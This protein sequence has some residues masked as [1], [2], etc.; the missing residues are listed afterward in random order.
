MRI[1]T[2]QEIFGPYGTG[3]LPAV[4]GPRVVFDIEGDGLYETI[5]QV[6][7][8]CTRD[9]DTGEERSFPP[10]DIA[11]GL[12]YLSSCSTLVGHNIIDFDLPV[13]RDLCDWRPA[14]GTS[15]VDTLV[16]SRLSN[17]DRRV[18]AG[19]TG[20]SGP[21]SL[22]VWGYRV[23]K[24]KPEHEDWSQYSP[25]M[26]ARCQ[27]DVLINT[28]VY[29][30][31]MEEL[32]DHKWGDSVWIEHVVARIMSEQARTG[33]CFDVTAAEKLIEKLIGEIA[34]VDAQLDPVLPVRWLQFKTPITKPF[35][36]DG[37]YTQQVINWLYDSDYLVDE[38]QVCGPFSRVVPE[39]MNTNSDK[40]LKEFLLSQGWEPIAYNYDKDG[41]PTSPKLEFSD[42]DDDGISDELGKLIKYRKMCSHRKSQVEGWLRNVRS[43]GR[44]TSYANPLGTPTGRMRHS[45]VVNVP[46]AKKYVPFGIEMRSLFIAQPSRVLVGYDAAGLELRMLAH[47]MNDL[48]F[49]E[50]VVNG[51]EEDGT[52]IHT[53]NQKLAGL[54][55]R[56]AAKT[57]IYAFNYGAGDAKLGAIAGGDAGLGLSLRREFLR[58]LPALDKLIRGVKRASSRGYLVG[59]DGRKLWVRRN[60]VT[61]ELQKNKALNILLQSAGAIVMKRAMIYL[62]EWVA[63][64]GLEAVKVLDMHDEAQWE[65]YPTDVDRF[66]ELAEMSLVK[67]GEYFKLNV[68]L[69][70]TAKVGKNW[71]ETH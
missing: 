15:I 37:T 23:G 5:T 30:K 71:A 12:Q 6:W 13:L 2:S 14:D 11:S 19:Y 29:T 1:P 51:R 41:N 24:Y 67:A 50:A 26:L 62:D 32:S 27:S 16:L 59:L 49:T 18:P 22:D 20:K 64:E 35:K 34:A 58:N 42:D 3:A 43:D 63:C 4:S 48:N 53:V 66:K 61:G 38:V 70:A 39:K 9:L 21:H 7:C 17:P 68:P 40:Q 44:L 36:K 28:L 46:K 52:D 25:E 69:A 45:N 65:V 55:T 56:D 8:I 54:P 47:Y 33:V 31:L 60:P 10:S 57:F